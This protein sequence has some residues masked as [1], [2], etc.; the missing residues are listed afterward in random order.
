MERSDQIESLQIDLETRSARTLSEVRIS[1]L[2][3][4]KLKNDFGID[5]TEHQVKNVVADVACHPSKHFL[6]FCENNSYKQNP[7][8]TGATSA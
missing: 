3:L 6:L 4:E 5:V 7:S 8:D 1:P 2:E